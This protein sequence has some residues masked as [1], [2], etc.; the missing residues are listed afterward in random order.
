M[1]ESKDIESSMLIGENRKFS[2]FNRGLAIAC[3]K[4]ANVSKGRESPDR[5]KK[6]NS[7]LFYQ[8]IPLGE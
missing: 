2:F 8:I 3:F 4:R 7:I 1:G 5:T 6:S